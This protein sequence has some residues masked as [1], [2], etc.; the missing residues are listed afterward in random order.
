MNPDPAQKLLEVE[1]LSMAFGSTVVMEE[2]TF[3]LARGEIVF[4]IGA[5]GCGKSTLM[6]H[7][8]GLLKP[9]AG[10]ILH[11]G[12][13]YAS[14]GPA[15]RETLARKFG[16]LFQSGALFSSLSLFDNV[17]LPL[18]LHTEYNPASIRELVRWK[19]ALVGLEHAAEQ[20]PHELSGGMIK[21]AGLARALA[22]D[23]ETLFCDEPSAGLDPISSYRLDELIKELSCQLNT[24]LVI[25]SHELASI[26][27]IA[28]K[29]V[30]LDVSTRKML[31]V[32]DPRKMATSSTHATIREFLNRGRTSSSSPDS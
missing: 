8:I 29:A 5:S 27:S 10:R 1:G 31:E 20:Y 6:R 18:R 15:S 25:V 3:D 9:A 22:L 26:F 19:L 17:A 21:R 7:L 13:D 14:L 23:P 28:D 2:I 11:Y 12:Q 32:G 24:G 16:I 30:F 4:L